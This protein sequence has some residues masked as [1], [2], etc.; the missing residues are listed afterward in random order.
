MDIKVTAS[1]A[2]TDQAELFVRNREPPDRTNFDDTASA[3]DAQQRILIANPQAGEYYVLIHGREGSGPGTQ[4]TLLAEATG[5][6]IVRVT[7]L[8]GSNTGQATI[9]VFGSQFIPQTMLSRRT[10]S[11]EIVN[12]QSVQFINANHLVAKFDLTGLA[13]GN[14]RLQADDGG[15]TAVAFD[16]FMVTAVPPGSASEHLDAGSDC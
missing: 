4:F 12:A 10:D 8:R 3:K 9:E 7:P 11:G 2:T 6:E 15:R 16:T 13:I 1:F 5:F 14:Y